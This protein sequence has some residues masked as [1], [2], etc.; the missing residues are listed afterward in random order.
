MN[1]HPATIDVATMGSH[2]T[3]INSNPKSIPHEIGIA[4]TPTLCNSILFAQDPNTNPKIQGHGNQKHAYEEQ[5]INEVVIRFRSDQ[6]RIKWGSNGAP[7]GS[8]GGLGGTD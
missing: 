4:K 5:S 8:E 7:N 2:I 1:I 3:I 6:K